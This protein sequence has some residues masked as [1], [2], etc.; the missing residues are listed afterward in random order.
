MITIRMNAFETNSSSTHSVCISKSNIKNIKLPKKLTFKLDNFGWEFDIL[1]TP[2]KKAS[3]LYTALFC[4]FDQDL[5][6][7]NK[8]NIRKFEEWKSRVWDAL[9]KYGVEAEFET[10][11]FDEYGNINVHCS[12]IYDGGY[13]FLDF[14]ESLLNEKHLI[15][16]LFSSESFV[17]T[18]NDN[19]GHDTRINVSYKHNEFAMCNM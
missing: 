13:A 12:A 10:P 19:E 9:W 6:K 5:E 4:Y 7:P 3:Y 16:Y 2:E 15:R 18:G 17:L 14:I 1:D 11:E 8:E